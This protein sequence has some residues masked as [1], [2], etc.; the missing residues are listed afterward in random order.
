MSRPWRPR[1]NWPILRHQISNGDYRM[2]ICTVQTHKTQAP[3]HW[4]E[5]L[6]GV[7]YDRRGDSTRQAPVTRSLGRLDANSMRSLLS[8]FSGDWDASVQN[9]MNVCPR[10]KPRADRQREICF[11]RHCSSATSFGVQCCVAVFTVRHGPL[12]PNNLHLLRKR[13][14]PI[15]TT[16]P[17]A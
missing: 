5:G 13:S 10:S 11:P 8:P 7:A 17:P 3:L 14:R 4:Q 9:S 2:S 15:R 12:S 6:C 1:V 16:P